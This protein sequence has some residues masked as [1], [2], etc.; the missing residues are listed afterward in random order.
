MH[1]MAQYS[2]GE[3]VIWHCMVHATV[4]KIRDKFVIGI[5]TVALLSVRLTLLQYM[6]T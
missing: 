5:S 1:H 4:I 6:C 2:F 3:I